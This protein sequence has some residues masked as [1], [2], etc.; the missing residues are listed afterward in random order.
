MKLID[1]RALQLFIFIILIP[2]YLSLNQT[3]LRDSVNV[4]SQ[5]SLYKSNSGIRIGEFDLKVVS[6]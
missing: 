1:V 6:V 2:T 4:F 3:G 5:I